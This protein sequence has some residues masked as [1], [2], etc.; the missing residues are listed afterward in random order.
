[1][2]T[3]AVTAQTARMIG[4]DENPA[5]RNARPITYALLVPQSPYNKA[6]AR[7]Q[8]RLRGRCT[9]ALASRTTSSVS[10]A[11]AL[12]CDFP[13]YAGQL[14]NCFLFGVYSHESLQSVCEYQPP[15]R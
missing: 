11:I 2:P 15:K 3:S 13:L 10:C 12:G 5:A 9:P 1:M 8:S 7:F 14:A 6:A 4:R